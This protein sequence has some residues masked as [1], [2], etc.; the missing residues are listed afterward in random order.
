MKWLIG[1]LLWF[2]C[3]TVYAEGYYVQFRYIVSDRGGVAEQSLEPNSQNGIVA[4]F[5]VVE[6]QP[7]VSRIVSD[8]NQL[9]VKGTLKRESGEYVQLDYSCEY[10]KLGQ[11]EDFGVP[12]IGTQKVK[13]RSVTRL[14]GRRNSEEIESDVETLVGQWYV[15]V[16][17]FEPK[18]GFRDSHSG[19]ALEVVDVENKPVSNAMVGILDV[20]C[21]CLRYPVKP[22][23]ELGQVTF[24][25]GR[26]EL[27]GYTIVIYLEKENKV[28]LARVDRAEVDFVGHHRHK[29]LTLKLDVREDGDV[30]EILKQFDVMRKFVTQP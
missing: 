26:E 4:E 6:G 19:V 12:L 10:T 2:S 22:T 3:V 8:G 30:V 7:F 29:I 23:N 17:G 20:P 18:I 15:A 16:T 14:Y 9:L 28:A 13:V 27:P 11:V 1:G 21:G 25:E 24:L 5:K